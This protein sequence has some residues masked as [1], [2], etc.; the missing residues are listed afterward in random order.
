MARTRINMV[1]YFVVPKSKV[2]NKNP[3]NFIDSYGYIAFEDIEYSNY[4]IKFLI[5]IMSAILLNFL[6]IAAELLINFLMKML[7][8]N[9]H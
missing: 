9:V 5:L 1:V 2:C 3:T 8:L 6:M 4:R 7:W